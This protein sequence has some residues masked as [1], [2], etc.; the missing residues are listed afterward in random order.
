MPAHKERP[1]VPHPGHG[2]A[3][4]LART[5]KARQSEQG[6]LKQGGIDLLIMPPKLKGRLPLWRARSDLVLREERKLSGINRR[7]RHRATL[8]TTLRA[9]LTAHHL[10]DGV[11]DL[12]L[13]LLHALM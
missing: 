11:L 4:V 10:I 2:N 8:G 1:Q 6:A 12:S 3:D 13:K 5:A 7:M 9:A